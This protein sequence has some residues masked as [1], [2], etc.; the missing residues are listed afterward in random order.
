MA[1]LP[2]GY[3]IVIDIPSDD[4][5]VFSFTLNDCLTTDIIKLEQP[6]GE[7]FS[8][9]IPW[10]GAS[11][12]TGIVK[13]PASMC[14]NNAGCAY[15]SSPGPTGYINMFHVV[16]SSGTTLHWYPTAIVYPTAELARAQ[17]GIRTMTGYTSY[18]FKIV[19]TEWRDNSLG[20]GVSVK[21]TV[22][23]QNPNTIM[24][25]CNT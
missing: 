20:T 10:I 25:S 17:F 18:T 7:I 16:T 8:G 5:G 19:D 1:L 6:T 9:W 11:D 12:N 4:G 22:L 24:F 14:T 2:N 23:R 13:Y 21:I 15:G 3:S